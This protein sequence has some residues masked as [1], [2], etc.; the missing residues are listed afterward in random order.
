MSATCS[1]GRAAGD[2]QAVAS[3][4]PRPR[5]EPERDVTDDTEERRHLCGQEL[6]AESRHVR[7]ELSA[8]DIEVALG[9]ELVIEMVGKRGRYALRLIFSEDPAL[10]EAFGNAD[11]VYERNLLCR[12]WHRN[13]VRRSCFLEARVRKAG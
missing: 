10:R 13:H 2:D 5:S 4:R 6:V 11:R 12:Q 3:R 8:E 7:L 9:R 1:G